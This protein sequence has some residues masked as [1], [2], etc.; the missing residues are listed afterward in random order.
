MKLSMVVTPPNEK[1]LKALRQ[2]G[3][4]FAVHYDMQDLPG[5]L[6]ALK[7]I[8]AIYE[9]HDLPW[10]IAEQGPAIDR[11]VMGKEGA[12]E[13]I[14]RYKRII[15]HLGRLGVEVIA[16]NFMP[17]VSEDAMV[18][19]TRFDATTRGGART[20]GFRLSDVTAQ[21]MPH[22]EAAIPRER[23]WDNLE[24][25]LKA[26]VPAA[27][28]AGVKLAMHPDDPPLSPLCGL[29]R[30]MDRQ[31]SFDRLLAISASPAN[32][33]TFCIGCFAEMGAD[34]TAL[35][36][37]Y[38]ERIPYV[39][40]RDISGTGTDFIET[41]PDDGQTDLIAVFRKLHEI[42]FD[43]Y[44]RSDHAPLLATD[45]GEGPEGYAIQGHLFAIGYLRGLDQATRPVGER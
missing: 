38:R 22:D 23:M 42:G 9:R 27:E 24:R 41:F 7:E 43:G 44:L 14:E 26:V 34:I 12:D 17:Q 33:I 37:R 28:A 1:R 15:G 10:K 40:V 5:D 13:Q 21:T 19:R 6:A 31:E 18:V 11:I 45:A 4:D 35:I 39:H 32:A 16:Y 2:L 20:S 8:R 3:G 29:E 30:I 36:E 25:F